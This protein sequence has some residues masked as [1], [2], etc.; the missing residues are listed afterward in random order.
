MKYTA[1]MLAT[2][3]VVQAKKMVDQIPTE[4]IDTGAEELKKAI[5]TEET[6]EETQPGSHEE[7][8][9]GADQEG[10]EDVAPGSGHESGSID[11]TKLFE[12]GL[13]PENV[14]GMEGLEYAKMSGNWFLHRTDEP[15]M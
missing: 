7:F 14:T 11:F 9:P 4:I 5:S 15:F 13:C 8:Q 3:A 6:I 2:L 12:P 10:G 1:L